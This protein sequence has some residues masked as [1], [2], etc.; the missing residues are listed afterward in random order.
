[1]PREAYSRAA[2]TSQPGQRGRGKERR[3][4]MMMDW[5]MLLHSTFE[6]A[7]NWA[8]GTER[9]LSKNFLQASRQRERVTG[10]RWR[11]HCSEMGRKKAR[12]WLKTLMV[13]KRSARIM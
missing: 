4:R 10:L 12:S 2:T 3:E 11:S 7:S 9:R 5:I 13:R 1:M 8:F 6:K